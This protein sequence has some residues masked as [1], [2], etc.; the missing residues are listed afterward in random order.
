MTILELAESIA[1]FIGWRGIS[2]LN[3]EAGRDAARGHGREPNQCTELD[4]QD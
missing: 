3:Q 1:S 2:P 4:R